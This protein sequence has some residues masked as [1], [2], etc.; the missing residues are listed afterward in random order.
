M[1]R[2]LYSR[3]WAA[4]RAVPRKAWLSYVL[5]CVAFGWLFLVYLFKKNDW[6]SA[7]HI[8]FGSWLYVKLAF[9]LPMRIFL[10]MTGGR[11]PPWPFALIQH[12]AL[13]FYGVYIAVL[14]LRWL[15]KHEYSPV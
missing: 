6:K 3:L 5:L 2:S 12:L 13:Y 15:E 7:L 14:A 10:E 9:L 4:L 1:F 8:Y 11:F